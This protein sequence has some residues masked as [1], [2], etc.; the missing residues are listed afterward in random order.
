MLDLTLN[1][2]ILIPNWGL[3]DLETVGLHMGWTGTGKPIRRT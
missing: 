2:M 1:L 3:V